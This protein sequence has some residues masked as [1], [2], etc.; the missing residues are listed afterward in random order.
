MEPEKKSNPWIAHVS[1]WASEHTMKFGEALKDQG[2]KDAYAKFKAANPKT[3]NPKKRKAK[4]QKPDED[5][6]DNCA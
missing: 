2:C 4:K 1:N 5:T 6:E 3:A